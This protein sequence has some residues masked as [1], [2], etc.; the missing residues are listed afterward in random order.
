MK[1]AVIGQQGRVIPA[2]AEVAQVAIVDVDPGTNTVQRTALMTPPPLTMEAMAGWFSRQ[3][4]QVVLTGGI[5]PYCRDLLEKNGIRVVV[6]VPPFRFEPVIANFL[7]GTLQTGVNACERSSAAN[8]N[9]T[10]TGGRR[11]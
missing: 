5:C 7:A 10:V 11:V 2:C 8:E 9:Q 4:V 6:G 1:I 3:A